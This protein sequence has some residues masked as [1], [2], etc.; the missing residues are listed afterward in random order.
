MKLKITKRHKH[1]QI[2]KY[3]TEVAYFKMQYIMLSPPL[4]HL[5][6]L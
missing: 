6:L 1:N 2:Q 3:V 5:N 4:K